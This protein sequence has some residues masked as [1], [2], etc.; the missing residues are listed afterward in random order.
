MRQFAIRTARG[1]FISLA[2]H[3][4]SQTTGAINIQFGLNAAL[5]CV[6]RRH[7]TRLMPKR[8]KISGK[9]AKV[10]KMT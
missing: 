3:D 7:Y 10:S 1:R 4:E 9:L 5:H 6:F 2:D 8:L